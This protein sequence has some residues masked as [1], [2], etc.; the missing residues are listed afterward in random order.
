MDRKKYTESVTLGKV[1]Q[2]P[3]IKLQPYDPTWINSYLEEEQ[4]KAALQGKALLVEHV[5]ST[6]VPGL[7]AKPIIDILLL[8]NDS[9]KEEDYVPN[10]IAKGYILRIREPEWFEHRMFKSNTKNV[11][12][13]VF[14]SGCTEAQE[15]LNFRNWLRI[16]DHDKSWYEA[17]KQKLAS[18]KWETVQE[19]AD[20]KTPIV[21]EIKKRADN[22]F[23]K[24]L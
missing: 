9:S 8:V 19:Y 24:G 20:A 4:K 22:Y 7:S 2:N 23:S 13:H 6:S 14:S 1:E 5:G 12:L 11:N 21:Q 3:Q 17:S 16:N 15:M 18:K 10:L